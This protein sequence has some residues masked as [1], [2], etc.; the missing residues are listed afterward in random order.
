[1]KIKTNIIHGNIFG[2]IVSPYRIEILVSKGYVKIGPGSLSAYARMRFYTGESLNGLLC[3]IGNY[4]DINETCVIHVGGEHLKNNSLNIFFQESP[5]VKTLLNQSPS[6]KGPINLG[7]GS[8]LSSRVEILSG[9]TIGNRSLA[10]ASS[11]ITGSHNEYSL[12]GGVPA[13]FIKGIKKDDFDWFLYDSETVINYFK[14][15]IKKINKRIS[16]VP[17][18]LFRR[19]VDE[20]TKAPSLDF[21]GVRVNNIYIPVEKL[22]P[23]HLE[24]FNQAKNG[25]GEVNISDEIFDDLT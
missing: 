14:Y 22:L 2:A 6:T 10:A 11:L 16:D 17:E 19:N 24:Y 15:G 21:Y 3:N 12:I 25:Q 23:H 20:F 7:H 13:K 1:M 5:L 9:A 18:L 8:V 4:C